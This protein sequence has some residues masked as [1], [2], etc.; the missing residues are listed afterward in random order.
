MRTLNDHRSILAERLTAIRPCEPEPLSTDDPFILT[1]CLQKALRRA[2]EPVARAAA[3]SL[4]R[5]DASRLWR[6]LAIVIF[7]DFG[8]A[9]LDLTAETVALVSDKRWRATVGGDEHVLRYLIG[10]LTARPRDRRVDNLYMLAVHLVRNPESRMNFLNSPPSVSLLG[11]VQQAARV[12][13]DCEH[14]IPGR[15]LRA[16][17]PGRC[18]TTLREMLGRGELEE[19]LYEV[20]SQGRRTSACLLPVLFP[21]IKRATDSFGAP[22]G[23]ASVNPPEVS[24]IGDLPSYAL[25]GFTRIGREALFQLVNSD[26]G[27]TKVV[28]PLR[29]RARANALVYL[30]FEAEGGICTSELRDPLGLELKSQALGCWTGLPTS[31]VSGAIEVMRAAI[32]KLNELR[33]KLYRAGSQNLSTEG[34]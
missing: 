4:L 25:D 29:G 34:V 31:E 7:E 28:R 16:V 24:W 9:D 6:R 11:V 1:S 5:L 12:V 32:T 22:L 30:L 17:I 10:E 13:A 27:V 23:L 33:Q 14:E 19:D 2:D 18:E 20:C 21:L 26:A 3:L 15:A 8:L